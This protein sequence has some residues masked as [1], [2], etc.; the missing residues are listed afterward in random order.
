MRI[1]V[2]LVL[3]IAIAAL[4]YRLVILDKEKHALEIGLCHN[5]L[6][7][8]LPPDP[9]CLTRTQTRAGWTSNLY[10]ALTE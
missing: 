2:I 5:K 10:Y 7:P 1:I 6:N 3:L 8:D 9:N 4:C